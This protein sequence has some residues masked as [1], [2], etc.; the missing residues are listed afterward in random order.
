MWANK[1]KMEDMMFISHKV[2]G[3]V[4]GLFTALGNPRAKQCDGTACDRQLV[5]I[6]HTARLVERE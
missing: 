4:N 1:N 3:G 5:R 6:S 2:T